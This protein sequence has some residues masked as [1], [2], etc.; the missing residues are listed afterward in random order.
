MKNGVQLTSWEALGYGIEATTKKMLKYI[1]TLATNPFTWA[2]AGGLALAG[3]IDYLTVSYEEANEALDEA[4]EKYKE[5][6][7]NI[8]YLNDELTTNEEK[9][10]ELK[11][12]E[13]DGTITDSQKEELENLENK[14]AQ[15]ETQIAL[16]K[17]LLKLQNQ[18]KAEAAKDVANAESHSVAQ[19]VKMGDE[20]GKS[21]YKGTVGTV[22]DTEAIKEDLAL[23]DEYESKVSDLETELINAKKA[24]SNAE[25]PF[26]KWNGVLNSN[27][28]AQEMIAAATAKSKINL[29]ENTGSIIDNVKEMYESGTATKF[30]T[31]EKLILKALRMKNLK[32]ISKNIKNIMK[33][34]LILKMLKRNYKVS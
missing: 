7:S 12:L 18:D 10:K 6:E 22:T 23:I 26:A 34:I 8:S 1:T 32:T 25:S 5:T 15:L 33:H 4:N 24:V 27:K 20:T 31:G 13:S 30:A 16:Q 28:V 11:K 17:E 2:I 3:V 19:S 14:N 9:I 29:D 21:T